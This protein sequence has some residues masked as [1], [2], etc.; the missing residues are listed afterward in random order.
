[1]SQ[2]IRIL[3]SA[4]GFRQ[5]DT[6][7]VPNNTAHRLIEGGYAAITKDIVQSDTLSKKTLTRRSLKARSK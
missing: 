5:G 6:V 4:E 1:M 2:R 7:V 3:K